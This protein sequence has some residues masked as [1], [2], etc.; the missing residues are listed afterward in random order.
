MDSKKTYVFE[1]WM[2]HE[3]E[4]KLAQMRTTNMP[5]SKLIT[6]DIYTGIIRITPTLRPTLDYFLENPQLKLALTRKRDKAQL[7]VTESVAQSMKSS[8][9]EAVQ[10]RTEDFWLS[11]DLESLYQAYR[12]E[13]GQEN[14]FVV[15]YTATLDKPKSDPTA[16]WGAWVAKYVLK[17]NGREEV[18]RM[19]ELLDLKE[20]HRPLA[21]V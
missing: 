17:E 21:I 8:G 20:I 11:E 12:D 19:G 10:R 7:I 4:K 2:V 1:P 16:T 6:P 5:T 18:Y 15:R 9:E 3:K 13:G 14:G